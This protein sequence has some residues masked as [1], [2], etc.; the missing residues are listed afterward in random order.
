MV[1]YSFILPWKNAAFTKYQ[2]AYFP[3][4]EA[5]YTAQVSLK[6]VAAAL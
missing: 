5:F 6:I 4:L 3:L 2:K 1:V